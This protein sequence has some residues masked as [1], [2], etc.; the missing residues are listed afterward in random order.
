MRVLIAIVIASAAHAAHAAEVPLSVP[1]DA[2]AKYFVLDK[3]SNGAM[4]TIITKR[5]GP[6]G[7]SYS[8]RQYDCKAG[9]VK[10]LGTG[11]SLEAMSKSPPDPKMAP[12]VQGS[13]AH[14]VGMEAC[15]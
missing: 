9:T 6:S 4:R 7:T 11:D 3:G 13:I 2:K 12:I 8:K 10:Y 1:S 14:Y 15:K 5:V